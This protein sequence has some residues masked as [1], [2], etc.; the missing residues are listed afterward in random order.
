MD[1]MYNVS[2][3]LNGFDLAQW[4]VLGRQL[5]LR[6]NLL[7][8]INANYER[9]VG[10]CVSR[11]LEAWLKGNHDEARFGP[12]TW[13]SLANAVRRSGDPALASR[14]LA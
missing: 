1:D 9:N 2:H 11:V 4:K 12:P 14:I 6:D 5:G 8:E 3:A 7:N 13:Y 10:E